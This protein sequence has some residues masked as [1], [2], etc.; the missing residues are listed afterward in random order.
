MTNQY[1]L[2]I[3][4]KKIVINQRKYLNTHQTGQIKEKEEE[5]EDNIR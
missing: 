1:I 3:F 5:E 2:F 4:F